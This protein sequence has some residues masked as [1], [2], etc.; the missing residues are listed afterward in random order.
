MYIHICI[1]GGLDYSPEEEETRKCNPSQT[2]VTQ[3]RAVIFLARILLFESE[4][5]ASCARQCDQDVFWR[6]G[7]PDFSNIIYQSVKYTKY[8]ICVQNAPNYHK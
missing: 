7:L 1:C 8:T 3:F 6:E 4:T 2:W 5:N